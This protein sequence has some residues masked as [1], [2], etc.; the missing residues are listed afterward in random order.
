MKIINIL[1]KAIVIL[2]VLSLVIVG[3]GCKNSRTNT[4]YY[5][6]TT[7]PP[8]SPYGAYGG[9]Q[10]GTGGYTG[11]AY[12]NYPLN[13]PTPIKA[14]AE[15]KST[16][17]S[18]NHD[19]FLPTAVGVGAAGLGALVTGLIMS[20]DDDDKDDSGKGKGN[21]SGGK[22]Q[23]DK[24]G[25]HGPAHVGDTG[26]PGS[27][28]PDEKPSLTM[29]KCAELVG[30]INECIRI[31]KALA[32]EDQ[33]LLD[34]CSKSFPLLFAG[35]GDLE[36]VFDKA[37]SDKD[38]AEGRATAAEGARDQA[39]QERDGVK[40]QLATT[41]AALKAIGLSDVTAFS[42]PFETRI[43][44]QPLSRDID[45]QTGAD[46]RVYIDVNSTVNLLATAK[47]VKG[48]TY[49]KIEYK[50]S[51]GN[52]TTG[53]VPA[54]GKRSLTSTKSDVPLF[55]TEVINGTVGEDLSFTPGSK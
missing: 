37:L 38:A 18:R 39:V 30:K 12:P 53:W 7:L 54:Y 20:G 52:V 19:W 34:K 32:K 27:V 9:Y 5:G 41:E 40:A 44:N 23:A 10:S 1:R 3:A 55:P 13:E 25:E 45:F 22:R 17:W 50:D 46:G 14:Q 43:I 35:F 6:A 21:G 49:F 24:R 8:Q 28:K 15:D 4:P 33:E 47:D 31:N 11:G 42:E 16:W 48:M 2:V 26:G 51:Q 36:N 29:E